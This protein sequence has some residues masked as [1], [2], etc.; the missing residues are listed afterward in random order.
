MT[1]FSW[2]VNKVTYYLSHCIAV[3]Q[4]GTD[5]KITCVISVCLSVL[6]QS[7][8]LTD[9]DQIWHRRL[10]PE[11]KEPWLRRERG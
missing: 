6:S 2:T 8:F 4:H 10:E 1:R 11:R 3:A 7:Q 5:Y 9:F